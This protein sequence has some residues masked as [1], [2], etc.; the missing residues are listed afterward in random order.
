LKSVTEIKDGAAAAQAIRAL[1]E[2]FRAEY[3]MGADDIAF[4][5]WIK[6]TLETTQ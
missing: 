6:H 1:R 3:M 4:E 5:M 2:Y